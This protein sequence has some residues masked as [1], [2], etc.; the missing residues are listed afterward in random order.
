VSANLNC[1]TGSINS[2]VFLIIDRVFDRIDG[3]SESPFKIVSAV[4]ADVLAQGPQGP[5]LNKRL[6]NQLVLLHT[7]FKTFKSNMP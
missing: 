6:G 1:K 7:L 3:R 5:D 2:F 4:S